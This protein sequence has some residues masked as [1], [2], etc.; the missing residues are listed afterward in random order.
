MADWTSDS[1]IVAGLGDVGLDSAPV[2]FNDSGTWKLIS[3]EF[4]GTFRGY[5]WA[6]SAWV[7]DSSIVDGLGDIGFRSI[8]TVF[9]DSGTWKLISG[10]NRGTFV[11]YYWNGSAWTSDSSIVAGLGAVGSWPAWSAP[12]VFDDSGTWK[13][14]SGDLDG[15]FFGF[16]WN[17]ST[18]VSDSSIVAGL[19]GVGSR[20]APT[21]FN[22]SGTWKLI[23]GNDY[24][25]FRGYYWAGSAWVEDT[26]IVTGLGDVGKISAPTVFNDSGTWKLISGSYGGTFTG[27][28]KAPTYTISG[29][30]K[31][32]DGNNLNNVT[33]TLEDGT[34]YST[35]T[36]ISGNYS[37][38]VDP[39]VY[40]VTASLSGYLDSSASVNASASDQ[41]QNFILSKPVISGNVKDSD[42]NNLSN[43]TISLGDG[44]SYETT[45]DGS[46]NY[47]KEVD[48]DVYTVTAS[49][50]G[51]ISSSA[52]VD[53]TTSNQTQN[54]VL[55]KPVISGNIKDDKNYNINGVIVTF[56]DGT[57]YETTTDSDGNYSQEVNT[58]KYT[59]VASL[60]GYLPESASV[61][62]TASD[63]TQNF[64][65]ST[66]TAPHDK[67]IYLGNRYL[68]RNII[69]N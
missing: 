7:S 8:P 57:S 27:Y 37:Q 2:V 55:S 49:K 66:D 65:L 14:I 18:W 31:D 5:Y 45:T 11:G 44:I 58:G 46:G 25:T 41:T 42:G 51:Y 30:V 48:A 32:S 29:N 38:V 64:I 12:A 22:D 40:T 52:S 67:G 36:N 60:A 43:V 28:S 69:D 19:G 35:N 61:D 39:D 33:I 10:N 50:N 56:T 1:S 63:Q 68:L 16:Y 3:G 6:G 47:S 15:L 4:Y 17:G 21:I 62:V 26:S 54:F 24:G 20:S 53:A 59:V 13:L 9:D 23:S 34:D